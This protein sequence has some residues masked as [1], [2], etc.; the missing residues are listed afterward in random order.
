MSDIPEHKV[1]GAHMIYPPENI[2]EEGDRYWSRRTGRMYYWHER[3]AGWRD[4]TGTFFKP[5]E[6]RA[7]VIT[8]KPD[9]SDEKPDEKPAYPLSPEK[10][11]ADLKAIL[12]DLA[13]V[14]DFIRR[15]SR[16]TPRMTLRV[17]RKGVWVVKTPRDYTT[18]PSIKSVLLT[19][20]DLRDRDT[21]YQKIW[22]LP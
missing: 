14:C 8:D 21:C 5:V 18:R 22:S 17:I 12:C 11:A 7:P 6:P 1:R 16:H 2:A 19:W 9:T 4:D 3:T 13:V 20:D 10:E 15:A